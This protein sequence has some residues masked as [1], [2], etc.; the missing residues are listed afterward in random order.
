MSRL[1][2]DQNTSI[3]VLACNRAYSNPKLF[4]KTIDKILQ[5]AGF[6]KR[7]WKPFAEMNYAEDRLE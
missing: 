4:M 6:T 7:K 2:R 5:S 1:D 3:S